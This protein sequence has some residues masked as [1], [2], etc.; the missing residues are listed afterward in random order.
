MTS[1]TRGPLPPRVYWTRRLLL[2]GLATLLV[3]GFAKVLTAGS[4]ASSEPDRATQVA[5]DPTPS[6]TLPV[7]PTKKKHKPKKAKTSKAPVLAEPD[8]P[9]A[10]EDI[11]VT[12]EVRNPVAGRDVFIVLHLRT[13]TSA[14]CTWRASHRS[15][16]LKISSG[17]DDIWSSR[18]CPKVI[19]AREVVVRNA[20]DTTLGIT[21]NAKRSDR[22]CSRLTQWA[23]PGFYHVN[24]AALAGEPADVQFEM[25]AP[26]GPVITRTPK[27]HQTKSPKNKKDRHGGRPVASPSGSTH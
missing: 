7:A 8:G 25:V 23:L 12:P 26:T 4:D 11:A 15:L 17:K 27:P 5:A 10:D 1:L 9:C 14:A 2:I 22:D 16:T 13:L 24:A 19:P 18:Q 21:W 6:V 20:V 3:V